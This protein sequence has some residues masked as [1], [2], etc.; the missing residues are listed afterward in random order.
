MSEPKVPAGK[1]ESAIAG[2]SFNI[3]AAL[4]ASVDL[5]STMTRAGRGRLR[6]ARRLGFALFVSY[7][8]I[9]LSVRLE[10][11]ES[12]PGVFPF[13]FPACVMSAWSGGVPGGTLAT[14]VL[15]FGAAYYHLPPAGLNINDSTNVFALCAF[16]FSGLLISGLV[17]A[18]QY[19]RDLAKHTLLS[20]GDGVITTDN[21]SRVRVMNP[22]AEALTGWSNREAFGK[23]LAEVLRIVTLTSDL[24][25]ETLAARAMRERRTLTL[26]ED[27]VVVSKSGK[28]RPL[29][30]SVAPIQSLEGDVI[31]AVIVFRDAT[32]RR[33]AEAARFEAEARYRE[34]FEN[35]VVGMFQSTP[36]GR[37]LR[38]NQA[39][40][41]TRGYRSAQEMIEATKDI[42]HQ[43]YSDP[44]LRDVF[45]RLLEETN[46]VTAFPLEVLRHDGT[47]LSTIVNA[48]VVRDGKGR[49]LYYEGTEE[50]VT[51]RKT[52]QAQFEH[53]QKM[54]AV[55]RLAGGV[56]HDFNN[57]LNVISGYSEIAKGK[58]AANHP[59]L[60]DITQIKDAAAR[61]ARLTRQLLVLSKQ[62][63]I[64]PTVLDLN[65]VV[66]GLTPMLE[67]LVG[68]DVSI[69][70]K[71][72]DA[73]GLVVADSGQIEQI[74][75]NL[76]VNAR[77]A[78]P[79]GG[80]ILIQTANRSLD[81]EYVKHHTPVAPG[82]YVMLSF[83]DTG[84]G[85]DK[86]LLPKIFE[87]FFTTKEVGK[88]TGLGLATVYGIVKQS[89]GN[90]WVYSEPGLGTTFKV[91][92]PRVDLSETPVAPEPQTALR[93]GTETILL[94]EDDLQMREMVSNMLEVAGYTVLKP[95]NST[96][97][98][99]VAQNSDQN[100][101]LL[102]TDIVMPNMSGIELGDRVRSSRPRIRLLYMTGYAGG[103]LARRGLLES[104]AAVI[105]KPFNSNVLLAKIRAA[106]DRNDL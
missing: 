29:D 46:I 10:G 43:E 89:K 82:R 69:S 85:I 94:V 1:P 53:A 102:L 34:I 84:Q 92:F 24:N 25:G 103:E 95:E 80:K 51:E 32:D 9:Y 65:K 18:L 54:E 5:V 26:P 13:L 88:G 16:V 87:P 3:L 19:H 66:N 6:W 76:G 17:G 98:L 39:L 47:R 60:R 40:A 4:L 35:A 7:A 52:L 62:Q 45:R 23:P 30:D 77:D 49:V 73:L 33:L 20:V 106:M 83:S 100:I 72:G 75:M 2:R 71:P 22:L 12:G 99:E 61:A 48:R 91:Y 42:A 31:G 86:F 15:A 21:R 41:V 56:A 8:S 96:A 28:R 57:I 101:D 105:E 59:I 74:L 58:V 36:D 64:Q 50:D 11:T 44:A 104:G 79:T 67:R 38:V 78:M 37:Y 27:A 93:G 90:I 81:K 55:G 97:A 70:F 14:I 68:E 63:V